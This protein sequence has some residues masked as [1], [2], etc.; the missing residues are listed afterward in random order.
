[1]IRSARRSWKFRKIDSGQS[2][3]R[4]VRFILD[5]KA[6]RKISNEGTADR[7]HVSEGHVY[8]DWLERLL[9]TRQTIALPS[10]II[11]YAAQPLLLV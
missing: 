3:P 5:L 11:L 2:R 9:R 4:E 10:G 7:S 8:I 6:F 1:M